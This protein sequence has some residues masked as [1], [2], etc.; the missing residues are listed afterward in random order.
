MYSGNLAV[1][2]VETQDVNDD[3]DDDDDD[4]DELE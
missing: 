4:D 1:K 2:L 3:D